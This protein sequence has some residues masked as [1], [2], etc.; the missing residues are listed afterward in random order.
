MKKKLAAAVA[1][2]ILFTGVT[3]SSVSAAEV[4]VHKGDSLW[5]LSQEHN[6]TVEQLM[7]LNNLQSTTIHPNQILVTNEEAQAETYTVKKG[8]TL[9]GIGKE[10][11]VTAANLKDWNNLSSD[12]IFIGQELAVNGST[13]A[14]ETPVA[15][16]A[17]AEE[18]EEAPAETAEEAPAEPAEEEP[19]SEPAEEPEP[20]QEPKAEVEVKE[21][22]EQ[23]PAEQE[24]EAEEPAP[25]QKVKAEEESVSEPAAEGKTLSVSATAYTGQCDGCSGVT[26]TGVDLNANPDAKVIAVDPS[27]IPLGSKVYVEGYGYA[28]AADTGGAIQGNKIDV[29]VPN[30]DQAYGWGVKNVNITIVE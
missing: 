23:Q 5:K 28:T 27:V 7:S 10:F 8:D 26:A 19:A 24:Q 17:P 14:P 3:V 20:E 9:S 12:L 18:T 29:H 16:E 30:K 6:T 21:A 25:E 2:G 22:P 13:A 1:T 11:G 15:E 4:E